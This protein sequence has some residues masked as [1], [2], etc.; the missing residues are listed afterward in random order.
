MICRTCGVQG[1]AD[2]FYFSC[3]TR[4]KAC[5]N[6][7]QL[8][9]QAR[10]QARMRANSGKAA[11][12]RV[13]AV[14]PEDYDHEKCIAVYQLAIDKTKATGVKHEVDHVVPCCKGGLHHHTN[15]QVLTKQANRKKGGSHK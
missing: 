15:L 11:A 5:Y 6:K 14:L 4:C 3:H 13:G 1:E 9:W 7:R 12:M 8:D 2:L 10:N